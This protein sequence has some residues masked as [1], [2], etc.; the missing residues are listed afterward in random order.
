MESADVESHFFFFFFSFSPQKKRGRDKRFLSHATGLSYWRSASESGGKP[1]LASILLDGR[2]AAQT[3]DIGINRKIKRSSCGCIADRLRDN[4]R[5]LL[6]FFPTREYVRGEIW[7]TVSPFR[8]AL[9]APKLLLEHPFTPWA[10]VSAF[11][12]ASSAYPQSEGR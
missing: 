7:L 1:I 4:V 10:A 6:E 12:F 11:L 5:A 9:F 3:N 2:V 8:K